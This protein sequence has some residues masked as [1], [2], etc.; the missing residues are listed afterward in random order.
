MRTSSIHVGDGRPIQKMSVEGG[1]TEHTFHINDTRD[2][3]SRYQVES[4]IKANNSVM[5]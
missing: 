4:I 3:P 2:I 1:L 5:C